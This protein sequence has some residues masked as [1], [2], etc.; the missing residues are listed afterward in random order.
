[1][2]FCPH[3]IIPESSMMGNS[4]LW[5]QARIKHRTKPVTLPLPLISGLPSDLNRSRSDP[6]I[7]VG[8][9]T[10]NT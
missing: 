2:L 10:T 5:L 8:V 7:Y 6:V 9:P 4:L 1:M 3:L